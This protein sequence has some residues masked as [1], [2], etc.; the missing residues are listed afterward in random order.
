MRPQL[1]GRPR[2]PPWPQSQLA[3]GGGSMFAA[4][5]RLGAGSKVAG[6]NR[7]ARGPTTLQVPHRRGGHCR[8][9]GRDKSAARLEIGRTVPHQ[10]RPTA[11]ACALLVPRPP[12]P[13]MHTLPKSLM[14]GGWSGGRAALWTG[15]ARASGVSAA[16]DRARARRGQDGQPARPAPH[17]PPHPPQ[18]AVCCRHHP[19]RHVCPSESPCHAR[20]KPDRP[21][22][23]AA[24]GFPRST[25]AKD[26]YSALQTL[27]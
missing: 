14:M 27:R 23:R 25:S 12:F 3:S 16:G 17:N 19:S 4:P 26:S 24:P 5:W 21:A 18:S 9:W 1:Q 10:A 7:L 8:L 15:A 20:D 6:A 2:W 13:S 11:L 22:P